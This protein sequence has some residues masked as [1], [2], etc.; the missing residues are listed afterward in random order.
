MPNHESPSPLV[1]HQFFINVQR[2]KISSW[3]FSRKTN[4]LTHKQCASFLLYNPPACCIF[5][6]LIF[7]LPFTP[8][9]FT[10]FFNFYV[11]YLFLVIFHGHPCYASLEIYTHCV[12]TLSPFTLKYLFSTFFFASHR[13]QFFLLFSLYS[14]FP[15]AVL[16]STFLLSDTKQHVGISWELQLSHLTAQQ[17]ASF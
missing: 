7:A 14:K 1:Q 17:Q 2:H 5:T 16:S 4:S 11:L 8:S 9:S 12:S 10:F 13:N 3:R 15:F 6:F